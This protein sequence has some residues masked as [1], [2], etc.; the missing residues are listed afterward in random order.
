M[1]LTSDAACKEYMALTGTT[2]TDAFIAQVRPAVESALKR[3][4]KYEIEQ[5]TYTEYYDGSGTQYLRLR[6]TPVTSITS[7]YE[8]STG[9]WGQLSGGFPST[10]LLTAG[11]DYYLQMDGPGNAYSES[12]LLVRVSRIWPAAILRRA[13]YLGA[14]A[15]HGQGNIKVT[16]VAGYDTIPDDIELAVWEGVALTRARRPHG[17]GVSSESFDGYSYSLMPTDQQFLQL[18]SWQQVVADRKRLV[19]G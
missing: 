2:A 3:V 15:L 13:G 7:V 10:A 5:A 6:Q 18:A 17:Q 19:I 8:S 14:W 11:S 12:G 1:P 9:F 4:V 16:Y